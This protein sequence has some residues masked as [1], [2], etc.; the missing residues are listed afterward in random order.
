MPEP[1][2]TAPPAFSR[3]AGTEPAED[4]DGR[5]G[6]APKDT[7]LRQPVLERFNWPLWSGSLIVLLVLLIAFIGPVLARRDPMQENMIIQVEE[8]WETPPFPPLNVPGFPLGS[9]QFGR[10][11]LSRLLWAVRPTMIMVTIVAVVRLLLGTAIGVGAGWFT[12]RVGHALEVAIG[13]ALA[14]P[15]LMVALGAIALIGVELGLL[16]FIIGLSINGWVETARLVREQTQLIKGN[17]YI[18]AARALGASDSHILLR[19]VVRQLMPLVWM[20]FSFEI[21][22]TLMTTAGLGF[23]GYYIGGDVWIDVSDFVARRLSGM[24]ELGQ[25]L[26]SAWNEQQ[27][28]TEPWGMIVAGSVVFIAVLGFNLLGEGLRLR[29]RLDQVQRDRQTIFSA[30]RGR[31]GAWLDDRDI[32]PATRPRWKRRPGISLGFAFASLLL[33]LIVGGGLIWRQTR[34]TEPSSTAGISSESASTSGNL[35]AAQRHD[36]QGTLWSPA[37]GPTAPVIQWVFQDE[38]GF[39]GSPAV[40]ADGTIY[41]TSNDGMLYA[42]DPQGSILWQVTLPAGGVGSPALSQEGQ[43]YV[44]DQNGSLSVITPQGDREWLFEPPDVSKATTGPTVAANGT[45]FYPGG[46]KL[47]AISPA[48]ELL[49]TQRIPYGFNPTP[50]QLDP[51]GELLF[52]LDNAFN[53]ADGTPFDLEALTGKAGNEQF[54]MGADGQTYYRSEGRL[55]QWRLAPSGIEV[56]YSFNKQVPGIPRDA[57]VTNDGTVWATYSP[58][59]NSPDLGV[60]WFNANDQVLGNIEFEGAPSQM[61]AVD[62]DAIAYACGNAHNGEVVCA[63]VQPGAEEA[64]WQISLE[65]DGQVTGGALVPQRLYVSLKGGFLYAIG[66]Q[67]QTT[68]TGSDE[69][70]IIKAESS[71]EQPTPTIPGVADTPDELQATPTPTSPATAPITTSPGDVLTFTLTVVNHGPSNA[72]GV[73]VTDTLPLSVTL[74]SAAT[75]QGI[76][77]TGIANDLNCELGDLAK[78]ASATVT[79]VV[80]VDSSAFGTITN[81]ATVASQMTD[82]DL[83]DNQ[84]FRQTEVLG[85][86]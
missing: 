5:S 10:D 35:W 66:A 27:V 16:A 72:S 6:G 26:A 40:A 59:F 54:I 41:L 11:L 48:G 37:T 50:P 55:L 64:V 82:P 57:G 86:D 67:E 20:L 13:V 32:S 75:S 34:G 85:N 78:G 36:A 23:L 53:T 77:C 79:V 8:G 18:E 38:A 71:P 15:V 42:L 68:A 61:I 43:I 1:S 65:Q 70:R 9:D 7:L 52:F 73:T 25:M 12:G 84:I 81:S 46:G 49:W 74:V 4:F 47:H 2:S 33:I 45:I 24:P 58:G 63:A 21:S 39:P 44:T 3:G 56:V 19:H 60:V 83:F 69:P 30:I 22:R 80:A 31:I 28:I 29:L 76:G 51:T 17:L 14:V 62:S